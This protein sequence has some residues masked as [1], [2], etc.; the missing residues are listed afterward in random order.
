[1]TEAQI[2]HRPENQRWELTAG[3]GDRVV[4]YLSYQL[5]DGVLDLQHTVVDPSMRGQGLGGRLVEAAM[6]HAR[7]EQLSVR[8]TCPFIPSWIAEHPEHQ[9]LVVGRGG[10]RGTS[11]KGR[12]RDDEDEGEDEVH[13]GEVQQVPIR[14]ESIRLGQLLKL[15]ALVQDGAMARMVIEN[16][17]VSVDGE[18]VVRRGTQVRPGEVVEYAGQ[19]I[20]PVREGR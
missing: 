6:V 12:V 5:A 17:E 8:P 10:A 20:T 11:A 13:D 16:S 1:M 3:T 15:A 7:Q 14:D 19:R 4:G 18:I 9:D 2:V